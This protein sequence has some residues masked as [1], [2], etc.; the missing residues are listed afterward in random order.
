MRLEIVK[1]EKAT[2]NQDGVDLAQR[3][4]KA[5]EASFGDIPLPKCLI[6]KKK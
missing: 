2:Y 6:K 4:R 3:C 5:L 1:L